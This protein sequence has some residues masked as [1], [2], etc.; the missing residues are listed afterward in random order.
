MLPGSTACGPRVQSISQNQRKKDA[1]GSVR[2]LTL[3][4]TMAACALPSHTEHPSPT[5][6]PKQ[7][8]EVHHPFCH[9]PHRTASIIRRA[10]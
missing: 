1:N 9:R 6:M 10:D 3:V 5:F 4:I 7:Q 8:N 2:D